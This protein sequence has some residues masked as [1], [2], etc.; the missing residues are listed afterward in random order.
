M[1]I[2]AFSTC[3]RSV[4]SMTSTTSNLPMVAKLLFQTTPGHSLLIFVAT[5]AASFLNAQGFS[6]QIADV[7]I[8]VISFPREDLP[9]GQKVVRK[10]KEL[11]VGLAQLSE[12]GIA[13]S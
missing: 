2:A 12:N 6:L 8:D 4:D 3:L 13:V 7:D 10:C 11:Q 1:I 5:S 9:L